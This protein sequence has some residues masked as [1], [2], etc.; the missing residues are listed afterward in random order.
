MQD[1]I[2]IRVDELNNVQEIIDF[3]KGSEFDAEL[4]IAEAK[5]MSGNTIEIPYIKITKRGEKK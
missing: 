2:T 5:S 4:C 1:Y 3:F